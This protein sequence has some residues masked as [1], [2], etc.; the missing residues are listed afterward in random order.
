MRELNWD[1]KRN[2]KK[3]LDNQ[4]QSQSLPETHSSSLWSSSS[5]LL[6]T[7]SHSLSPHSFISTACVHV[8]VVRCVWLVVTLWT[9]AHQTPLSMEFSR[10][11]HQS[12]LSFP[13]PG[14]LPDPGI[15]P[16]SPA[17]A[18]LA[19]GFLTTKPPLL[20]RLPLTYLSLFPHSLSSF[21]FL[22]PCIS[23]PLF[24]YFSALDIKA[25]G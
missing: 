15:A 8:Q 22:P 5:L 3:K 10:P 21:L 20:S 6:L 14:D 24:L 18:V 17:S 25:S 19:G 4:E 7:L 1:L 23:S 11:V 13:P 12:R 9:V 2:K 16:A